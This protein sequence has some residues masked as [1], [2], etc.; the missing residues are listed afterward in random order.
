VHIGFKL[1][2]RLQDRGLYF[3]IF[4]GR[5]DSMQ[6]TSPIPILFV[7]VHEIIIISRLFWSSFDRSTMIRRAAMRGRPFMRNHVSFSTSAPQNSYE[8]TISNLKI[9][10]HTRVIFQGFTG[11]VQILFPPC[12]TVTDHEFR[13]T[14][15][16]SIRNS[17]NRFLIYWMGH[18]QCKRV[19]SMGD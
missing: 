15:E 19:N 6:I 7:N 18:G 5:L 16:S 4:F 9:G 3:L 17:W 11:K 14:S 8:D 13:K 10:D 1:E 2:L 12:T